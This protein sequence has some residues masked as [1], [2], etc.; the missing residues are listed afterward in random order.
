MRHL[1]GEVRDYN[2]GMIHK[3]DE[4]LE[5]LRKAIGPVQNELL[6]EN[7]FHSLRPGIMQTV[8]PPEVLNTLFRHLVET[9]HAD[10]SDRGF[11][12]KTEAKPKFFFVMI[13]AATPNF[14]EEAMAAVSKLKIP[15]YDLTSS[16]LVLQECATLGFI[17]RTD[18]L[19]HQL[20]LQQALLTALLTWRSNFLCEVASSWP[21]DGQGLLQMNPKELLELKKL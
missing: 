3:Q 12:L 8:H 5:Q 4:A 1:L 18:D 2:G 6:V 13:G 14:R 11:V 20:Q 9:M 10:L 17:Y 7:F 19:E 15:S 21:L 16:F